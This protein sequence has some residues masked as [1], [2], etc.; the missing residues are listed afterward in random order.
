MVDTRVRQHGYE[1]L[2]RDL[3]AVELLLGR[4]IG[5]T[6]RLQRELGAPTADGLVA[7]LRPT[8]APMRAHQHVH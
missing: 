1:R 8:H 6:Q 5:A 2:A 7:A 4:R 3:D